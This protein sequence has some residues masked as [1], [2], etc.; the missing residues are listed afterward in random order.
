[1]AAQILQKLQQGSG[2]VEVVVVEVDEL[3]MLVRCDR[4]DC[5]IVCRA[6]YTYSVMRST[7]D[8]GQRHT[9]VRQWTDTANEQ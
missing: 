4:G 6:S 7:Y 9:Q 1:V 5:E 8:A 3:Q 2:V